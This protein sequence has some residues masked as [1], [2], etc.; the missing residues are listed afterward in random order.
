MNST[1]MLTNRKRQLT[2][3]KGELERE[4]SG[5]R[6]KLATVDLELGAIAAYEEHMDRRTRALDVQVN[7]RLGRARVTRDTVLA[8]I[9]G[10]ASDMGVSRGEIIETLGV[11]G[12]KSGEIAVDNRLRELK[13]ERRVLHEGRRYRTVL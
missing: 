1:E 13:R 6:K 4:I 5:L 11:K 9:N 10:D 3:K 7:A 12:D 2:E 8:V